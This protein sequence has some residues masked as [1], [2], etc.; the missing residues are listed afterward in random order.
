MA[1]GTTAAIL[2]GISLASSV[3]STVS[4]INKSNKAESAL[5][6]L[7]IPEFNNPFEDIQ[8]STHGSDLLREESQRTTANVIEMTQ[9]AGARGVF[10]AV[11]K[12]MAANNQ[13]N[14]RAA[15]TLDDQVHKRD[16]AIANYETKKNQIEENRY[17]Q[18]IQGLGAMMNDGNQQ[19][20]NGINNGISSVGFMSRNFESSPGSPKSNPNSEEGIITDYDF[21]NFI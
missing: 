21:T 6:N 4:G 1:I 16:Y 14:Q 8:I 12:I 19:M 13:Q 18:D 17:Q 10:S 20:W 2:G 15:K 3:S 7:E 9:G 5:E 11:P